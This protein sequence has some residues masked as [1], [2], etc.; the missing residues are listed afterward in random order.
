MIEGRGSLSLGRAV[1]SL[2][3]RD[4]SSRY[5][6]NSLSHNVGTYLARW[7]VYPVGLVLKFGGKDVGGVQMHIVSL[8][9]EHKTM[10][11]Y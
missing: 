9:S 6:R 5:N 2:G 7:G 4:P 8:V 11:E 1:T 10:Y 3:S